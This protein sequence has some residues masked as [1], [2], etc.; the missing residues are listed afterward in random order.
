MRALP[1]S[2]QQGWV[3][4]LFARFSA[5]YGRLF[6]DMWADADPEQVKAAWAEDLGAFTGPQIAWALEQARVSC[7]LPP[8]LPRF[9]QLCQ[10]APR[11]QAAAKPQTPLTFEQLRLRAGDLRALRGSDAVARCG[12]PKA[13]AH[14]ILEQANG[15]PAAALKLAREALGHGHDAAA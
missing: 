3:E 8:T 6:A 10:Q 14:R 9:R 13:W 7:E 5:M 4:R 11:G 1:K 12:D 2:Q 15:R